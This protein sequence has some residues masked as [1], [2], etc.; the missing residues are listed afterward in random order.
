MKQLQKR[1]QEQEVTL[2]VQDNVFKWIVN[3]GTDAAYG[4]RPL[5]RFIQ[6]NL[7]TA[8]AK[9]LIGGNVLPGGTIGASVED[10]QLI[11]K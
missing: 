10:G 1:L 9:L 11:V 3:E 2:E 8:V 6:R 5:R 4:A 7:E